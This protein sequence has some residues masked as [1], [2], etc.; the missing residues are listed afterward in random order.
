[1]SE[2]EQTFVVVG[3]SLAGAK[4][5]E[6]LREEGFGGRIVLVGSEPH[7]PYER[8]PLSKDYLR[9]ETERE[10][11]FV[12]AESFYREHE[13][14]LRLDDGAVAL[15]PRQREVELQSGA[16]LR[17]DRLL[18]ATGAEPRRLRI[19]G[20]DLDGVHYLR[21]V[22][23]SDAIRERL[24]K[25]SR[26][27]VIGAGWIGSEA[28]AS[29]RQEGL[30]VIV[31]EPGAVPLGRVLGPEVGAVYRDVHADHGVE[32]MLGVGVEAFEGGSAVERV[33]TSDGS[34]IDCDFVIAGIGVEPRTELALGAGLEVD[35]GIVVDANLQTSVPG[36]FAAGDVRSS[37][38][39][40]VASAVGEGAMAVTLVHRY[41]EKA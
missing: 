27:V 40:R 23:S 36:V 12:H 10:K 1:M 9:G 13:I 34:A 25:G 17:F 16:R 14:E 29:A 33:R 38:V 11:L 32:L 35:N 5:V 24:R 3:A 22:E 8:P 20:A 28:A 41:L 37:S 26:V 21:S 19:P 39:K 18:L 7:R 31:V 6:T 30:E 15:D 2:R 4:A